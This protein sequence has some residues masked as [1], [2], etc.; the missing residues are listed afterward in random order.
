MWLSYFDGLVVRDIDE[1]DDVHEGYGMSLK[2]G[3]MNVA[4]VFPG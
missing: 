4:R 1:F 3:R 2:F